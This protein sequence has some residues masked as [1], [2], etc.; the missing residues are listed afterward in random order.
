MSDYNA[1]DK[2][3]IEMFQ[4]L[5]NCENTKDRADMLAGFFVGAMKAQE[6]LGA[7]KEL[8]HDLVDMLWPKVT[9]MKIK[10]VFSDTAGGVS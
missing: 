5:E 9:A 1:I 6:V 2:T 8:I 4:Q 7:S 10:V 3:V